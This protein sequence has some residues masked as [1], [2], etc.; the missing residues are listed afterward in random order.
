MTF[1]TCPKWI[2]SYYLTFPFQIRYLVNDGKI[3]RPV[4][5]V[6]S[7]FGGGCR[8]RRRDV[9][10]IGPHGARTIGSGRHH[11]TLLW[12]LYRLYLETS[13]SKK[14]TKYYYLWSRRWWPLGKFPW[15]FCPL[16]LTLSLSLSAVRTRWTWFTTVFLLEGS[17]RFIIRSH[18][19]KGGELLQIYCYRNSSLK[20]L[21]WR[22]TIMLKIK[23]NRD[24]G[25]WND[26]RTIKKI[27][28]FLLISCE[29]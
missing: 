8:T 17:V 4:G 9:V 2:S 5:A 23:K 27:L 1:P 22:C 19:S 3:R 15:F 28:M 21:D 10:F 29:L 25:C 26:I 20:N 18:R 11:S 7:L 14:Y 16:P 24:D 12:Q 6:A 13:P